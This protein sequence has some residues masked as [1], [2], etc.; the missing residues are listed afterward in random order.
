MKRKLR[1]FFA[2]LLTLLLIPTLVF[3]QNYSLTGTDIHL[4]V[5][6]T[7]WYVFTRDNIK[8]NPELVELGLTYEDMTSI[9]EENEAYM[10]A[11]LVYEDGAFLELFVR[12]MVVED[13]ELVNLSN[14]SNKEVEEFAKGVA[15]GI[16]GATSELYESKYK[17][18]KVEFYDDELDYYVC[19]FVT[20]VNKDLYVV[21]FQSLTE[22]SD[23]EYEEMESIVNS[24]NFN[25]DESLKEPKSNILDGVL[26][27]GLKGGLVG[28]IVGLI[29]MGIKKLKNKDNDIE[30]YISVTNQDNEN[31]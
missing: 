2:S 27:T 5:D 31:T 9:F 26:S 10:D 7:I 20:Y 24:V 16:D 29:S 6:D 30:E 8:D 4:T 17:F 3:A 13:V 21:S 11:L 1:N 19:E 15:E 12:K 23:W 25:I 22:F 14:Y 28:G 18:A